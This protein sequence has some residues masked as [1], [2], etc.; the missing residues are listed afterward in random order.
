M[1]REEKDA[2]DALKSKL[3][4]RN[5][6]TSVG[7]DMRSPL[8]A[9]TADAPHVWQEEQSEVPAEAAPV[10]API[11]SL[12]VEPKRRVS[13]AA[14]FFFVSISFFI[15]AA[16]AAAYFFFG[17]GNSISPQ[18]IDL[19]VV[20][21]SLVD[22]GKPSTFQIIISN[23]NIGDLTLA[24][25]I[26]DYPDGTRSVETVGTALTHDR[27]AVG[28]IA[29]GQQIKRT[30]SAMFFGQQGTENTI[31]VTLEYS[32]NGSNSFFQKSGTASFVIGSSPVSVSIHSPTEA[33]AGQAFGMDV[34]VQANGQLPV[35]N[36]VLQ[37]QYPYGFILSTSSPSAVSGGNLWRLGVLEPGDIKT[38][39]ISGS[40]D[41][42][43]GD[44]RVFRFVA[45][46]DASDSDVTI[47]TPILTVP[48]T[49]T[50]RRPFISATI[51]L[52][53]TSGK[54]V[55]VPPGSSVSG[56]ITWKNNLPTSVSNASFKLSLNGAIISP[57]SINA[58]GGFYQSSDSSIT[59]DSQTNAELKNVAAG[60]QGT[61]QFSFGTLDLQ[62]NIGTKP[63]I[64]LNLALTGIREGQSGVP[65]TVASAATAQATVASLL[66]LSSRALYFSGPFTNTGPVPPVVGQK[67][68][69]TVQWG[70]K[71]SS[72][73]VSGT[74]VRAVLPSYVR[75][76]SSAAG[77]N[78]IYDAPTRTVSWSIG[79]VAAGTGYSSEAVA[80]NFQVELTPSL[81]QV[82]QPVSLTGKTILT[83]RDDAA[84][85]SVQSNA[86]APTTQINTDTGYMPSMGIVTAAK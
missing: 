56:V 37:A 67:T 22:A 2:V 42:Q 3:Y 76:V 32:V 73:V 55:A 72:S 75:F 31:K 13:W 54:T 64:S 6:T 35:G 28:T 1:Q 68:T 41:G 17:G 86:E 58:L 33:I 83:G 21:P 62:K 79:S 39:H 43:D 71:N 52:N 61:L 84:N 80:G 30:T 63:N 8:S 50:V 38:I 15:I 29:A 12:M 9:S 36:V 69:Y 19:Q 74:V 44:E 11:A 48:A 14:K 5:Q 18:N 40:I 34:T 26:I 20:V 24:D 49:L 53:G 78:I 7:N 77:S 51:A 47:T 23:H 45:G 57:D 70:V 60:A 16:G 4:S 27:Q 81:S 82:G 85:A 65:D 46:T 59:W 66:T 25:L 10:V